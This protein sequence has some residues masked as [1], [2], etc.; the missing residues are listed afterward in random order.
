MGKVLLRNF[1][2]L[3]DELTQSFLSQVEG[4]IVEGTY[5][6]K[7]VKTGGK[8]GKGGI[9][10]PIFQAS[11]GA[12]STTSAE[13]LRN[14]RETPEARFARLSKLLEE[15]DSVQDLSALDQAIYDSIESGEMISLHGTG[16]LTEW[17]HMMMALPELAAM[18]QIM[19]QAGG[20]DALT[21]PALRQA[22][23]GLSAL[24][25]AQGAT[26]LIINPRGVGNQRFRFV[27]RLNPVFLKRPKADLEGEIKLLG[28]V[29]RILAPREEIKIVDLMPELM[30]LL[31]HDQ[32][33][34]LTKGAAKTSVAGKLLNDSIKYPTIIVQPVGIYQ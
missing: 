31:N 23:D 30:R 29:S 25:K 12:T 22:Y 21:D 2:Y 10:A 33:R 9:S 5:A 24:E 15:T 11:L 20:Q 14:L 27:S 1:L 7:E 13:V 18:N 19:I 6:L 17:E 28:R 32:R 16:R 8:E 26:L 4:G 3:D 34:A